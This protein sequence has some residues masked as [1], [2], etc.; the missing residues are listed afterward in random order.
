[1]NRSRAAV[2]RAITAT[3]LVFGLFSTIG[4]VPGARAD[5]VSDQKQKIEQL[6]AELT[7][8][9]ERIAVLDEEYGAALD[10]KAALD[11]QIV[12]AQA[13]LATEQ[14]KMDQLQGVMSDIA[15]QKFV[16][17]NTHN[18][19][20]LFSSAAAYSSGEQ[21]DALSNIA[22]DAGAGNADDL[23]SLIRKVNKDTKALQAQQQQ[24]DELITTLDGQRQQGAQLVA[25][26][27][28]K[29]ADAKAKYGELV[30]QE[31]D[32][33]AA[34]AA[35]RAAATATAATLTGGSGNG[36]DNSGGNSGGST[37]VK[38]PRGSG[39]G[40]SGGGNSNGGSSGGGQ[41][42]LPV[43]PPSGK[44]GIAVSAAHTMLGV[45]YVAF[46]A[47]PSRGFDCSGLT[48][49][50]WAQ[51]G[52]YMPHQSRAQYASFP[53]V[54]K[55]QAQ[56]GDLVFFYNPIHHVGIYVGGG[57]MIDAPHTGATV[58]LVAVKWGSVVGVARPG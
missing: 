31:S 36:N 27:T 56:P 45:P 18:L 1:M 43:P 5:G 13:Q 20:P 2:A 50:A 41:P 23:Q 42:A 11:T 26:Y 55:D 39:G 19:S 51:A 8:L 47:S 58:R 30:Q 38:A 25:E 9:N 17:N 4:V 22:F 53:H 32:R 57:M 10:Q 54:G 49:W 46:E 34:A 29:A 15:V 21:K 3:A 28:T 52:V 14:A 40:S 7:N 12:A 24:A 35:E 48:S 6:A 33:Q 37:S 16:G 44:A